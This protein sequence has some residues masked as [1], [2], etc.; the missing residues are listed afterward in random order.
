MKRRV[1]AAALAATFLAC[2]GL[3]SSAGAQ[4]AADDMT[5]ISANMA[6]LT[7]LIGQWNVKA[8]FRRRDGQTVIQDGSYAVRP[9]LDGTYLHCDVKLW[10][11]GHP[12][13]GHQFYI[14]ITYDPVTAAYRNTYIYSGWS[15]RV[16]EQGTFD[17]ATKQY[18]T[19]A[20]IP[21]ED[22]KRD[23]IVRTITD[24]SLPKQVRYDHFSRYEDE[25]AEA[26]DLT[27]TLSPTS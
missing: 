15:V 12:E 16:T 22:G 11:T 25:I 18:R 10:P 19:S 1:G 9:V 7:P 27:I 20:Y 21:D 2:L 24:L 8:E 5:A 3:A 13:R 6:K 17:E 23:E 26:H 4:A 14:F